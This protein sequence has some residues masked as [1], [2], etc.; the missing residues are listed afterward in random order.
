MRLILFD[1]DGTLID[2]GGAG[3]RALNAA[4]LELFSIENGFEGIAMAGRTDAVI[5]KDGLL[6]H[7]IST[8]GNVARM[9]E[10]YLDHLRRE[11]KN[12]RK[13]LKPGILETLGL[14]QTLEDTGLGLLTGN[15]ETG[16]RIKLEPFGLNEFFAS[17]AF[18]SDDEDR[19]NLLP[20]ALERYRRLAGRTIAPE[21][22][23]VVGD[24]PRDIKCAHVHGA[25]CFAVATG[26]YSSEALRGAGADYVADDLSDYL[27][28]LRFL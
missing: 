4:F 1:I 22:C 18:G 5:I 2:T 12:D 15:L 11:I 26:P 17:G 19:N 3:V 24:T 20:V 8:D 21:R 25:R 23:I 14:L 6:K 10:I 7:G 16:A 27:P 13:R 28:L 9:I